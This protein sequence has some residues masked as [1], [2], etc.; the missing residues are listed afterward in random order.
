MIYTSQNKSVDLSKITR[1]YP[2][3]RLGEEAEYAQMSL[4]WTETLKPK[5]M[6]IDAYLLVFDIDPL[7]EIPRNRIE[8]EFT[9][10][11]ALIQAMVDVA[12]YFEKK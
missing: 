12:K 1:L 8:L 11:D 5:D 2:A 3:V 9:T 10:K 6:E 4:E 7:E